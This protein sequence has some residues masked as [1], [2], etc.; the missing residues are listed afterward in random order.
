MNC[1][2]LGDSLAAI[3]FFRDARSPFTADDESLLRTVGPV[4]ATSLATVVKASEGGADEEGEAE[5]DSAEPFLDAAGG[6]DTDLPFEEGPEN[7][8]PNPKRKPKVD[9]SDWWKR[10]EQPPF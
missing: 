6:A 4:F 3:V 10:G 7:S 8:K 5:T 2:Y 1:T 9:P